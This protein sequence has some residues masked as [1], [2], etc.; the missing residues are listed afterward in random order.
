MAGSGDMLVLRRGCPQRLIRSECGN[1]KGYNRA[2]RRKNKK[3]QAVDRPGP[4]KMNQEKLVSR[5]EFHTV[6][7]R[8]LSDRQ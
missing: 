1:H 5:C 8:R 2:K 3:Y 7:F 6:S 4:K